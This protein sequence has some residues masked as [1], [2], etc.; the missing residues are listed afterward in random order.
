MKILYQ[1]YENI[2]FT[3]H[4]TDNA[5][6]LFPPRDDGG[7]FT[8]NGNSVRTPQTPYCAILAYDRFHNGS[9]NDCGPR[10]S[11]QS[12]T[13]CPS[14]SMQGKQEQYNSALKNLCDVGIVTPY[15]PLVDI[16]GSYG[17][18]VGRWCRR[19]VKFQSSFSVSA[20]V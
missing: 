12:F 16:K 13:H 6:T 11:P 9:L 19:L 15:P 14:Y 2:N 8:I 5:I 1:E 3:N 10:V 7:S 17:A 20:F 18:Q 4:V